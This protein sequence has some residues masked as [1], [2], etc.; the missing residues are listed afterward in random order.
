MNCKVEGKK[1]ELNEPKSPQPCNKRK[2]RNSRSPYYHKNAK[3]Q[4]RSSYDLFKS[5]VLIS[6]TDNKMITL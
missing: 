4:Y 5:I 3:G 2:E 6:K 1:E